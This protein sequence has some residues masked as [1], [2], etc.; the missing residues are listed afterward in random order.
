MTSKTEFEEFINQEIKKAT[1]DKAVAECKII[2]SDLYVKCLGE[3]KE[4]MKKFNE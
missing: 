1:F 4:V 2:Q 3:I